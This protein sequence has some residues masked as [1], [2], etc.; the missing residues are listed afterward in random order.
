MRNSIE[1]EVYGNYALF[2]D[3]LTKMGGEK[4]SYQVPTYQALK[5]IVESI[6]WKPT[7][8]MVV[9][10]IRILKPIRMESKGIRPIEY[11]GG[12]TLANYTYLK[13]VRYQVRA[14]FVFN[15]HR[16]ELDFDR[17]ENKH[18][19]ILKRAL[20]AGG[21]RDIFL[22]T[23]ECQ[24]YVEPCVFGEGK[25]FYDNYG[26]I[27]LGTMFHGINYPDETARN[28]MEVRLWNPVMKDGLIQFVRPEECIQVRVISD[29]EA[30][31]FD[32]RNVE[33]ANNLFNQLERG[34]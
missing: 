20:N 9:D 32:Y 4:L 33:S 22:G 27:H 25:G 26:D 34:R 19:N 3:P 31:H 24:A 2:T 7:L 5:G 11:G 15:L 18:H 30:K 1:F 17:N 12:N 10:E 6:Y 8:L 28:Q 29:M 23:R 16:P 14:H 21:R 13:D